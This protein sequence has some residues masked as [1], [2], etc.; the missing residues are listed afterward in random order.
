MSYLSQK[1]F[2]RPSPSP[3]SR[4]RALAYPWEHF[5]LSDFM[6]WLEH[7]HHVSFEL[8]PTQ[9]PT[10]AFGMIWQGTTSGTYYILF[11]ETLESF[12]RQ[13]VILHEIGHWL[14]GHPIATL[15]A[16]MLQEDAIVLWRRH[17][18]ALAAVES[19]A[20]HE[21]HDAE[22]EAVAV[23]IQTRIPSTV[24]AATVTFSDDPLYRLLAEIDG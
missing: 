21:T 24:G 20:D 12:H 3:A 17:A 11:D 1:L 14:C 16:A 23:E 10:T 5:T 18:A 9:L 13:H 15:S 8:V 4:V 6:A 2:R 22:A 7:E 19:I